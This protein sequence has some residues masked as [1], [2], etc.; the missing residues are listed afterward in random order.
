MKIRK[1]TLKRLIK[2]EY[3]RM[4]T[5]AAQLKPLQLYWVRLKNEPNLG[6]F[7][8]VDS[9]EDMRDGLLSGHIWHAGRK[10]SEFEAVPMS[11]EEQERYMKPSAGMDAEM[12][13]TY[14]E[15]PRKHVYDYRKPRG[16]LGT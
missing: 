14:G 6:T 2:E 10:V 7:A 9:K 16:S 8:V 4:Q 15:V 3:E 13:G 5:E 1:E 12:Y 11:P